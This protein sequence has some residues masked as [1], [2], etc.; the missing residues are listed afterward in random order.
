MG[1][2][3]DVIKLPIGFEISIYGGLHYN[4]LRNQGGVL[5]LRL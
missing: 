1:G 5:F 2:F 3:A 4:C